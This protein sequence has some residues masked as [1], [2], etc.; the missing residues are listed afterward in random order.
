MKETVSGCFF[1]N[2]VYWWNADAVSLTHRTTRHFF[3]TRL[4]IICGGINLTGV[5]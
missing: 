4:P 5:L 1:L 2:T 3:S